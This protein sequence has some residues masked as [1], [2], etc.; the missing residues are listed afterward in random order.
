MSYEELVPTPDET[1]APLLFIIIIIIIANAALATAVII[2]AGLAP[3]RPTVVQRCNGLSLNTSCP[4]DG[5][6]RSAELQQ[7]HP[8]AQ[9]THTPGQRRCNLTA[10]R[11]VREKSF[12]LKDLNFKIIDASEEKRCFLTCSSGGPPSSRIR[13]R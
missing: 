1:G 4:H 5:V 6:P 2:L 3:L 12:F 8:Q 10:M 9:H 13:S 7:R 11:F